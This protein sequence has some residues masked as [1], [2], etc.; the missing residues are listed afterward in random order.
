MLPGFS[1][2]SIQDTSPLGVT[3]GITARV[4]KEGTEEDPSVVMELTFAPGAAFGE[5][6]HS[7]P[8]ILLVTEGVFSDGHGEYGKGTVIV[9]SPGSVHFPQ[10]KDGCTVLAFHPAGR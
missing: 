4:V 9:G 8:E 1:V 10:S 7:L 3:D 6:A 5:D 2:T